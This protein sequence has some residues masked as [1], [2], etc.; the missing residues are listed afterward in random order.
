MTSGKALTTLHSPSR[1]ASSKA[2]SV[3]ADCTATGFI[4]FLTDRL[5]LLSNW[6][7][8]LSLGA[9]AGV[10]PAKSETLGGKKLPTAVI[11]GLARMLLYWRTKRYPGIRISFVGSG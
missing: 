11:C 3:L 6:Q 7:K 4:D 2:E 10:N 8:S 5:A 9:W 1:S